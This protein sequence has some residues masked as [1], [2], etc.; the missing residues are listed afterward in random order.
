MR[1]DNKE[2]TILEAGLIFINGYAFHDT[3]FLEHKFHINGHLVNRLHPDGHWT[4]L[5]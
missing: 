2:E 5:E 4:V 1:D 3:V